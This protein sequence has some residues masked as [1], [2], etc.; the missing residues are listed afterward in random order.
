MTKTER[1]HYFSEYRTHPDYMKNT[2]T[3]K[4]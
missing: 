3:F 4:Q 2:C 1:L